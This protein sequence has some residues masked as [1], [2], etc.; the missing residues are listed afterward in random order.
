[1]ILDTHST[2]T[3][4]TDANLSEE[5]CPVS[6]FP[7]KFPVRGDARAV[8]FHPRSKQ[9]IIVSENKDHRWQLL[10]YSKE[11]NF[12]RSIDLDVEQDYYITGAA[13][14]TDGRVCIAASNYM[15]RKG[16]VL[17]V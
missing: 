3:V 13:V 17:V 6:P 4:F 9:V 10:F 5:D 7:K 16:M 15:E 2:V 8:T 14:T 12:E 1:M 11:G